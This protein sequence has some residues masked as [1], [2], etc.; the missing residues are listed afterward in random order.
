MMGTVELCNKK[1]Q[2]KGP[3]RQKLDIRTQQLIVIAWPFLLFWVGI[4]LLL[5]QVLHI[6]LPDN[7]NIF[8]SEL[9][10]PFKSSFAI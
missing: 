3:R 4:I 6:G 8:N 5:V 1:W 2:P 10:N 7:S 9:L